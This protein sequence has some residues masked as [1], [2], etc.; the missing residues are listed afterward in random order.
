MAKVKL[1][2]IIEPSVFAPYTLERSTE[3]SRL[4]QSGLVVNDP[5]FN[6]L[7]SGAGK[8]INMPYWND[9]DGDSEELSDSNALTPAKIQAEQDV[10]VKHFRGKSWAANDLAK[11][12]A[13]DDPMARIADRVAAYWNRDM[14]K[15][16][17]LNSL[18]GMFG[19]AL[20]D[21]H[22]N[23]IAGETGNTATDAQLIGSDAVIDTAGLLGDHWDRIVALA[24]HS[25]PFQR[26]QK[27]GLIE[28]EQLQDQN[29]SINR[30]LGREVI[31]DDT[32][33]KVAGGTNG[34]KYT[35]YLFGE[36]SV[37]LGNSSSLAADEAIETDRDKLAGDDILISRRHFIMHPRGVAFTGSVAGATPTAAELATAGNWTKRYDD[38]NIRVLKLVTNG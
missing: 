7:A 30:F 35:T 14:Q 13:G 21:T 18:S 32:M 37:G 29:I 33:P 36:G 20:A 12:I 9:L 38:K 1:S 23:D 24:M 31:V 2:D 6:E 8:T 17:L 22:V 16:I 11:Y 3:L 25:K 26:L 5:E 27:L 34:F 4:I 15:T 19:T 10:A 28:T